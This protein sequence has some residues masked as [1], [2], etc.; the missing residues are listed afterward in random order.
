[1]RSVSGLGLILFIQS[2]KLLF[3]VKQLFG[4]DRREGERSPRKAG[5]EAVPP[6]RFRPRRKQER[7]GANSARGRIPRDLSCLRPR[8]AH[9][10]F[11]RA[12]A[13]RSASAR[14]RRAR[15]QAA[16]RRR[17]RR[18]RARF[19]DRC[20]ADGAPRVPATQIGVARIARVGRNDQM[21]CARAA[22]ADPRDRSLLTRGQRHISRYR[23][24]PRR[25]LAEATSNDASR[26][27]KEEPR[28]ERQGALQSSTRRSALSA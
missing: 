19:G 24:A 22:D 14:S 18:A 25:S 13:A 20:C 27:R 12:R 5:P 21:K 7:Q 8:T 2:I 3:Q 17:W 9:R 1:M 23:S 26:A 16:T 28:A 10:R 15:R 11:P 4:T 6:A